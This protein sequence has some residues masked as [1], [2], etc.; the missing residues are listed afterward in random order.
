MSQRSSELNALIKQHRNEILKVAEWR[1]Q[2][3]WRKRLDNRLN[4]ILS[5]CKDG[6]D[7][8]WGSIVRRLHDLYIWKAK[9]DGLCRGAFYRTD[10]FIN[11]PFKERSGAKKSQTVHIEHTIP[12]SLIGNSLKRWSG[13]S[14]DQLSADAIHQALLTLSVCT[15]MCH[16]ADRGRVRNGWNHR[17]PQFESLSWDEVHC[18]ERLREIKPF[19]RYDDDVVVFDVVSR[20]E[21]DKNK[22][23]LLDHKKNFQGGV[24]EFLR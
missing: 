18:D 14:G 13:E 22:F 8:E 11:M 17:H 4:M 1:N 5:H 12:V 7:P 21:I 19:A 23:S 10:N 3:R 2:D 16:S 20:E 15:A 24:G 6:S 9:D